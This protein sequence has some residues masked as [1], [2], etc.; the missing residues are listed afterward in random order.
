MRRSMLLFLTLLLLT[1]TT[2]VAVKTDPLQFEVGDPVPEFT[3]AST[4][5]LFDYVDDIYG[6]H[7]LILTFMPAAFTPV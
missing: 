7:H 5:G 3:L 2:A 6:S 1:A 4:Q